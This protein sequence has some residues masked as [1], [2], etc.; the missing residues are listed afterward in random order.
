[1]R[2]KISS[3]VNY[4]ESVK[5]QTAVRRGINNEPNEQQLESMKFVAYEIFDKVRIFVG[6][7]LYASSFFRSPEL[8]KAIGGASSSQHCK[9]EAIDIDCD[10]YGNGNN[11]DVFYFIE[12]NLEFD[13]LIWEYGDDSN[14]AWVHVSRKQ[15]N[16]RNM[17]LQ[18]IR[19][20][21]G[22][23]YEVFKWKE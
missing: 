23:R 17:I 6:G 20:D 15:N 9:G 13:Q 11:I 19:T 14:P 5:S 10:Y 16:N 1:M 22:T 2:N 21:N 7:P 4:A 3:Y 12:Q 8:N 18:A